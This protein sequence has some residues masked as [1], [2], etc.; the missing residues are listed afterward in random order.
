[1]YIKL[2]EQHKYCILIIIFI[3]LF[4]NIIKNNNIYT[5]CISSMLYI[6]IAIVYNFK[7]NIYNLIKY[8]Y[9]LTK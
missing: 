9:T 1:M 7:S 3:I 5:K 4:K 6:F 8:V 2:G